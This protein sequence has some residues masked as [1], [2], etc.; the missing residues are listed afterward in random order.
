MATGFPTLAS[1]EPTSYTPCSAEFA[2]DL[3]PAFTLRFKKEF[4]PYMSNATFAS[5]LYIGTRLSNPYAEKDRGFTL[6]YTSLITPKGIVEI[7]GEGPGPVEMKYY[8]ARLLAPKPR[9][10]IK[11]SPPLRDLSIEQV[12]K[13]VQTLG[14]FSG[15][16]FEPQKAEVDK[17]EK[18]E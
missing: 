6:Y 7:T 3:G 8:K 15:P 18:A 12:E 9:K 17:P 16:I 1:R 4:V 10:E 14:G 5:H 2:S 13:F 11:A